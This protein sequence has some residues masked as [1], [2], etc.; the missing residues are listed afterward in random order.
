MSVLIHINMFFMGITYTEAPTLLIVSFTL[1]GSHSR[2][3]IFMLRIKH[4]K[5]V[6]LEKTQNTLEI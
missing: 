2:K 6:I 1:S 4:L 5:E 3:E